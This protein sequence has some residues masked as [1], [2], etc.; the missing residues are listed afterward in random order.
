MDYEWQNVR[1]NFC[2]ADKLYY[3][4]LRILYDRQLNFGYAVFYNKTKWKNTK[5]KMFIP[6]KPLKYLFYFWL[7]LTN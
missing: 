3:L 7:I 6:N 1:N 5:S 4:V 2:Y